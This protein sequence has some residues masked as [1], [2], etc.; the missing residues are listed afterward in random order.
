MK[1][2]GF[3]RVALDKF[4]LGVSIFRKSLT[5]GYLQDIFAWG[6]DMVR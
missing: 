4:A 6:F 3:A 1:A 2:N 5:L